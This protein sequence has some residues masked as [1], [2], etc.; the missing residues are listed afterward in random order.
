MK[1]ISLDSIDARGISFPLQADTGKKTENGY[2]IG[3]NVTSDVAIRKALNIGIDRQAL[4]DGA[5]NGQ[6]EEEFTGVDKLPWGNKEAIFEDGNIEEAK[7]ILA[8]G[9]WADTDG[10]GIVEKNGVKAEFTLLYPSNALDRQALA[11]SLSEE[12]RKLGINVKVEGKS[13]NEIDTLAH[14]TPVL[15]G[16]GSLDPTDIYL[17]YYSKSYDPSNYNN[18]IMY[19]NSAVDSYLRTAITSFDEETA[20]ENWQLA[21]W[22]GT[23]GFSEKGDATWLWMAT[24]NYVYIMDDDLDIGTPRIQPHGANIFGNILEWKRA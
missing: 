4:I 3:N 22:D 17:K 13:W 23:T 14:S 18:V 7:E 16:F 2:A 8:E 10:D 19:N 11:V 21:A 1:T 20:N 5:L 6:G 9:G 24:I 12:A 15:F